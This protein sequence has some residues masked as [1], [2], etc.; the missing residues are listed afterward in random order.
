MSLTIKYSRPG[1]DIPAGDEKSMSFFY[2]VPVEWRAVF[3]TGA[4]LYLNA[5]APV[6][7]CS[8]YCSLEI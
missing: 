4:E 1:N 3:T 8:L 5:S 6:P 7:Y 2:S